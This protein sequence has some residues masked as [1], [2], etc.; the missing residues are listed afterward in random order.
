[1][2]HSAFE[3]IFSIWWGTPSTAAG[4]QTETQKVTYE[5]RTPMIEQLPSRSSTSRVRWCRWGYQ[6]IVRWC[7]VHSNALCVATLDGVEFGS[8]EK[9][10]L[11][12]LTGLSS[13]PQCKPRV[14]KQR[15]RGKAWEIG[16]ANDIQT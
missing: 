13:M 16:D 9:M 6:L 7:L 14:A 4:G 11:H 12:W 2:R 3:Q 5:W 15:N 8:S 1:L 10:E